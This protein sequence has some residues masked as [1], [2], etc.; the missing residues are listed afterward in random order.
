MKCFYCNLD[1]LIHLELELG[2]TLDLCRYHWQKLK[3]LLSESFV[4][5]PTCPVPYYPIYPIYPAPIYPSPI[6]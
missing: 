5:Q 6:W 3:E 1:A 4:P 2:K